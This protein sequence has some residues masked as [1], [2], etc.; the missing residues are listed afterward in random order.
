MIADLG[1]SALYL[2][3]VCAIL[4]VWAGLYSRTT[5]VIKA[6]WAAEFSLITGA[7]LCLIYC[8]IVSDFTVLNVVNN[9]HTSKPMVYKIAAAW[10]NHEGSML[11]WISSVALFS[12]GFAW[13]NDL[14]DSLVR[15]TLICQ[16]ILSCFFLGF[17]IFTSNPFM[18]IFPPPLDGYGLNPIL[19]DIGLALHP[20][21]L[22]L[23]YVGFSLAYSAAIAGLILNRIDAIWARMLRPWV[24]LSWTLL[25]V[26]IGLG[27]WWA[28]RELGWGGFWFW[29]PVENASLMPWLVGIAL[30][31]ALFECSRR[32][33]FRNWSAL[34]AILVFVLSIVGT[35]IVRSGLITS[36]HSFVL[37]PQRGTWILG[38]LSLCGAFGFLCYLWR[39]PQLSA[40]GEQDNHWWREALLW[41]NNLIL[42][43][44]AFMV[45][46][47]TLYPTLLELMGH[48]HLSVGAPYYNTL[49]GALTLPLLVFCALGSADTNMRTGMLLKQI[50]LS[51]RYSIG[52]A[53]LITA[54]LAWQLQ[55][56]Q[57]VVLALC[58]VA[59]W[60]AI[61]VIRIW[62]IHRPRITNP[63]Y[64]MIFAHLGVALTIFSIS[65]NAG[66][67]QSG[68]KVLQLGQTTQF[69]DFNI[70]LSNIYVMR[71]DNYIAKAAQLDIDG[72]SFGHIRLYPELRIYPVERQQTAETAIFHHPFYDL[73]TA[74]TD[75][76]AD[77]TTVVRLYY[78]PMMGW[79]WLGCFL[80]ALG[81]AYGIC[82]RIL[83]RQ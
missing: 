75:I 39:A 52:S 33:M 2:A 24:M 41:M 66:I 11:L 67:S 23:G 71:A 16:A 26:G 77:G 65:I 44:L 60:L 28:Y 34:L 59:L 47:G 49:G 22:Y 37:D 19:Q 51:Q 27:S 15:G 29:D 36:V 10:G 6:L 64:S 56:Q 76:Q 32:N 14:R 70:T 57:A 17:T 43:V 80:M 45:V 50:W 62:V 72:S 73:Y 63:I 7:L 61:V 9:S 35:F 25:T 5:L 58:F 38:F 53:A 4:L 78:K 42:V 46:I 48:E 54:I 83:A 82:L 21:V 55:I 81:A 13:C 8:Y 1:N 79:L 40:S 18:R 74:L 12:L 68:E 69:R 31:H 3:L 20:P 30:I